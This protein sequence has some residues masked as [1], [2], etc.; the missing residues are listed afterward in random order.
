AAADP[1][2]PYGAALPWPESSGRPARAAG[3]YVV[4]VAGEPA[5]YL[6]RG[7]RTLRTFPA[8]RGGDAWI[9]ALAG[10]VK[11]GR[12]RRI[13]LQRLDGVPAH[14]S[15]LAGRLRAPALCSDRERALG[16]RNPMGR[17]DPAR[18][19]D[20]GGGARV[21]VRRQRDRRRAGRRGDARRR[22]PAHVRG[23]RRPVRARAAQGRRRDRRELER[24]LAER[25]GR[26]GGPRRAR[27]HAGAGTARDHGSGRGRGVGG[28]PRPGGRPPLVRGVR[29][30]DRARARRRP[31][32]PLP[33]A[34]PRRGGTAARRRCGAPIPPGEPF[35][36]P[37]LARTL[38][39]LAADGAGALYRG[40][41]GR[42][43]AEGLR[44]LGCPLAPEDL[45][46]HR[47]ELLAPLVG[48]YR[49][50]DVRV[51][52]PT[53]QGF[54][55]LE[56]LGTLE[57]LGVDPD[58]LGPDAAT[59]ALAALV[60][61]R[62]RDLHLADPEHMRVHPHALLDDGHLAALCDQV[63]SGPLPRPLPSPTDTVGIVTADA[64]GL[65][66]SLIQSLSWGLGAGILEPSTGI[67]A[68]NRGSGF[69]LDSE[70]PNALAPG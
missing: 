16:A 57:R 4:L 60:A 45:E 15:P 69:T 26:R 5:A 34:H 22:L 9:D 20:R 14:E 8:A 68:Q 30:R 21:R 24:R 11:D 42:A 7:A 55:L 67:I 70:H 17:G 59:I 47:A 43:Y 52:P 44:R 51:P 27:Q 33:R 36:N 37:A 3:A 1:A 53:S 61:A 63:R 13:E 2:Q 65:A 64:Q 39:V 49:D 31:R 29:R 38:E 66:V 35:A 58:P 46:A 41:L 56:L 40:E 48:R 32:L 28:G 50:L 18:R 12:V 6:E 10:L 25:P 62:D 54:V 23:R 19:G